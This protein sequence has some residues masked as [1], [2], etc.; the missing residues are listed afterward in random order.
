M[1]RFI[2]RAM[3]LVA[4]LAGTAA[5]SCGGNGDLQGTAPAAEIVH[6]P[7]A[8]IQVINNGPEGFTMYAVWNGGRKELGYA[9]AMETVMFPL[10]VID[11]GM[12]VRAELHFDGGFKCITMGSV[13]AFDG[14]TI[15]L[16]I[17]NADITPTFCGPLPTPGRIERRA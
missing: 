5:A 2:R 17:E 11:E 4:I 8:Y 7:V 16:R 13:P 6:G 12:L 14:R 9:H 1:K 15:T 3:V 10:A